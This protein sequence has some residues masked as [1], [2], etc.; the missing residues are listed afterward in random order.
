MTKIEI[1]RMRWASRLLPGAGERAVNYLLDEIE[2]LR[3]EIENIGGMA[4]AALTNED[5][6]THQKTHEITPDFQDLCNTVME[7]VERIL[8]DET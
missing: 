1:E 4:C 7:R 6:V 3:N 8:E 2:H 5:P